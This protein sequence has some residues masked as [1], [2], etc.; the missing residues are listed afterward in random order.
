MTDHGKTDEALTVGP[1]LVREQLGRILRSPPFR[2]SDRVCRFLTFVCQA[3]LEG[4][5]QELKESSIGVAVFDRSPSYDQKIDPIVRVEARRLRSKLDQ[6]YEA[7]GRD[8]RIR[9][10]LPKGGY[11]PC[12][13]WNVP[14]PAPGEQKPAP[15]SPLAE[16]ATVAEDLKFGGKASRFSFRAVMAVAVFSCVIFSGV[17]AVVYHT[18]PPTTVGSSRL[19][20][21]LFAAGRSTLIVPSDSALVILQN[22]T[23]REIRLAEYVT[24]SWRNDLPSPFGLKPAMLMDLGTRQ[25]MAA[26]EMQSIVK[27]LRRPESSGH[28]T[29]V[30]YS[31]DLRMA[32]LKENAAIL[33]GARQGNP[34]VELFD[35]DMNFRIN[36]DQKTYLHTVVNRSPQAGEQSEYYNFPGDPERRAYGVVAFRWNLGGT[37]MVLILEGT[38][39]AGTAAA[40]DFALRNDKLG[41][42]LDTI[43]P[44][45]GQVPPFELLLETSNIANASPGARLLAFRVY[46]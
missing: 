22:L 36:F 21:R 4:R 40:T 31:R 25:Y 34:W 35:A 26:P 37:G 14:L 8:D 2:Q 41:G 29:H 24:G 43:A 44:S 6:F 15:E 5:T 11:I 23:Q 13:E 9:I 30:V 7:E 19:W 38:T 12:F 42:F 39:V 20:S 16:P 46:R 1:D 10:R 17:I 33:L 27:L 3:A 32:D 18:R 45:L 28:D